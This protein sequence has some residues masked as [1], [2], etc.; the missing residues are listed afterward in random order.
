MRLV[1]PMIKG[2][3][4]NE[5]DESVT[6]F[7]TFFLPFFLLSFPHLLLC[8]SWGGGAVEVVGSRGGSESGT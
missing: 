5:Y 1:M 6:E 2:P 3:D 7:G 8:K 4:V